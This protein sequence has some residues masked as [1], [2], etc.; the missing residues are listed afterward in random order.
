[1][2]FACLSG[3]GKS[4]LVAP[5]TPAPKIEADGWVGGP[6]PAAAD[7]SGRIVVIDVWAYWCDPCRRAV[8]GLIKVYE[9]YKQRGV[10]FI[11]LTYERA[12]ALSEM[13]AFIGDTHMPWPT[14]YGAGRT[15]DALGVQV[16]P[17]LIVIDASGK[18]AWTNDLG[19]D[20]SS[21]LDRALAF[22]ASK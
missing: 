10:S 21:A 12:D 6:A 19:G 1:L 16:F 17:T 13:Q 2:L 9:N 5:G 15:L 4:K 8:P 18:V 14:G 11:G 20:L 7:F 3:C 22:P